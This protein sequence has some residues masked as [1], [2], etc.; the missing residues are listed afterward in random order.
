MTYLKNVST[1]KLNE[2]LCVGCGLCL[3]VCPHAVFA[4][5]GDKAHLIEP[6][7]CM[8]CGA[9]AKNCP[10][11]ALAVESGTGCASGL[12]AGF[13]NGSGECCC[14]DGNCA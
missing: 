10:T 5:A 11:S 2:D 8:E 4:L 9:C 6:D 14:G 1:L 3:A 7:A 12:I 13:F